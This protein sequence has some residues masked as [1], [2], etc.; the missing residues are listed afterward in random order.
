MKLH[1]RFNLFLII[2][3]IVPVFIFL[4]LFLIFW[5]QKNT[6]GLVYQEFIYHGNVVGFLVEIVVGII[7]IGLFSLYIQSVLNRMKE[8]TDYIRLYPGENLSSLKP[9]P[10]FDELG[11]LRQSLIDMLERVQGNQSELEERYRKLLLANMNLE[12]K[13]AQ[14]YTIRLILEEISRELEIDQLLRKTSDIIVGVFG[15]KRCMIYMLDDKQEYLVVRADTG[16]SEMNDEKSVIPVDSDN[17]IARLWKTKRLF[18]EADAKPE[19]LKT[20]KAHH[21]NGFHGF[22][23]NGRR[24]SLGLIFIEHQL[25]GGFTLDLE[26]FAKLIAQEISLSIENAYIYEQM[27]FMVN[28]DAL[29]GIYNRMYL[30]NYMGKVFSKS[31]KTVSVIMFDMDHFKQ[32]NDKYGHLTGDMVLRNA[33]ALIQELL[34]TGIVGRYGGE[35]FVVLLPEVAQ[36]EAFIM[37]DNIRTKISEHDFITAEGVRIPV[38]ISAGLANYPQ[39]TDS[40]KGLLQLADEALYKAKNSGRNK[41]CIAMNKV[42][43]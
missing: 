21:V 13:Y 37:A 41:V 4:V 27:R 40:F 32:I 3:C 11:K 29:T 39:V 19:E 35:E 10:Y 26:D 24:G 6:H 25:I 30:M 36:K 28:H 42:N 2:A 7:V 31:P 5:V 8:L 14:S 17:I 38:S 23:L 15:S 9:D 34:P 20:L 33:T 22:P 1:T 16:V 18:S 12:E 43:E